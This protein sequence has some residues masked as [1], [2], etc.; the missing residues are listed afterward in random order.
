MSFP[1]AVDAHWVDGCVAAAAHSCTVLAACLPL[2]VLFCMHNPNKRHRGPPHRVRGEADMAIERLLEDVPPPPPPAPHHEIVYPHGFHGRGLPVDAIKLISPPPPPAPHHE[3]VYPHGFHGRGLPVDAIKLISEFLPALRIRRVMGEDDIITPRIPP[4]CF[5]LS[6][7]MVVRIL[8]G[9]KGEG[10]VRRRLWRKQPAPNIVVPR[11]AMDSAPEEPNMPPSTPMLSELIPEDA[12]GDRFW[13]I[14][15]LILPLL[16]HSL[17][18]FADFWMLGGSP[19]RG[20]SD[21]PE[22]LE[23][24]TYPYT[25]RALPVDGDC[26][27]LLCTCSFPNIVRSCMI[28]T[29]VALLD[30]A[31]AQNP[32]TLYMC[33]YGQKFPAKD[34]FED[35]QL[36][37]HSRC[38]AGLCVVSCCLLVHPSM[39]S[40]QLRISQAIKDIQVSSL[41][42]DVKAK[43]LDHVVIDFGWQ[44]NLSG[45]PVVAWPLGTMG[46][47][48]PLTW[49]KLTKADCYSAF[50]KLGKGMG[51]YTIKAKDQNHGPPVGMSILQAKAYFGACF[52]FLKAQGMPPLTVNKSAL[53][54][55]NNVEAMLK[56]SKGLELEPSA[57]LDHVEK[58][59]QAAIDAGVF[60]CPG[61]NLQQQVPAWK[62]NSYQRVLHRFGLANRFAHWHCYTSDR[63]DL[64]WGPANRPVQPQ[65]NM[66]NANIPLPEGIPIIRAQ[67]NADAIRSLGQRHCSS[68]DWVA[69]A[70][71]AGDPTA[72][73]LLKD[74]CYYTM[75]RRALGR[76]A[77]GHCPFTATGAG[78]A[79]GVLPPLGTD[80]ATATLNLVAGACPVLALGSLAWDYL[81]AALQMQILETRSNAWMECLAPQ[82]SPQVYGPVHEMPDGSELHYMDSVAAITFAYMSC[83]IDTLVALLDAAFAQN[84]FTLYCCILL[85]LLVHPSMCS[86]QLRISDAIKDVQVSSLPPDVKAKYLDHVVIDFGWQHNLSGKPVVAWP[87]G[88]MGTE[89]PLTWMQL[90]KADCYS[91][92]GKLGKG[93]G[94]YTIKAKDQNHGPPVGM[95]VLQAKAYCG[96]WVHFLKA[97]D[98][99]PLTVSK[100]ALEQQHNVEAMLLYSKG[101]ELDP[102]TVLDHAAEGI[103][104][105]IDA[106]V[107]TCPDTSLHKEVPA[108]KKIS[109]QRGN[110][111]N[112]NIP[113][114]EGIPIIRAQ[115]NADAIRSLGK[116]HCSSI[117]WAA[118]ATAAG[119]PAAADL[120]KD[121]CYYTMWR[122][123][124]GRYSG[125]HCPFTATGAGNAG[126]VLPPLGTDLAT[127]TLNLVAGGRQ[128]HVNRHPE[129]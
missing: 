75:W 77:G 7:R 20:T 34:F 90:A 87:L 113:L 68:I 111:L 105:A 3:I 106:G 9:L 57:I 53:E 69:L 63:D 116:T 26:R 72:A 80:L 14:D 62:K 100:S 102:S 13:D 99:P 32:F 122:R 59:I 92:F 76:Y 47:E 31:F 91:A 117:D 25:L 22:G 101:L 86:Q 96:A 1:V 114:P 54:Q 70:T 107:F 8:A 79:G 6:E 121:A 94:G 44:H 10:L 126:G 112:A 42:P 43:Y 33:G 18:L 82:P 15:F 24:A 29:L 11:S 128:Y 83:I 61:S 5:L 41:L 40:Q 84:P 103:N 74:A 64:T 50:G 108:W 55:Q 19:I 27:M 65:G 60:T 39:C 127:A 95:S 51:G 56:Y 58:G 67:G 98:M 38:E 45:K 23:L 21:F 115:G 81:C 88:T 125:G 12:L 28:E 93:M 78:N 2:A 36:G 71:A 129:E 89:E 30:A 49:M 85:L 110:M 120:L 17:A 46:T 97:Q 37:K 35:R 109:Y 4:L 66:L 123:A 104:A 73:D 16:H 124:L 119:E 52:H 118:L 48:E